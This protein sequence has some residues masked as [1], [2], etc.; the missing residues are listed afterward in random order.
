MKI[1]TTLKALSH[2]VRRDI[3]KRLREGPLSA[4]DIAASYGV[5]KPTMS[6]HFTTLKDAGLIY[7]ERAGN[8]II[9][10]LEA[11]AAEEAL[12]LLI[13]ILGD[14]PQTSKGGLTYAKDI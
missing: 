12:T 5:S 11:S 9:Y 7:S 1:N 3:I 2:P 4:G 10:Y 8:H 6:A 14:A 13:D